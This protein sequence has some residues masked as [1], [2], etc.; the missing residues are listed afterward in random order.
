[1]AFPS[2]SCLSAP[3]LESPLC[4]RRMMQCLYSYCSFCSGLYSPFCPLMSNPKSILA[5]LLLP[6]SA[7]PALPSC[8]YPPSVSTRSHTRRATACTPPDYVHHRLWLPEGGESA[9]FLSAYPVH[10]KGLDASQHA[11]GA[12]GVEFTLEKRKATTVRCGSQFQ[13]F[14]L[15]RSQ[16]RTN[17][18]ALVTASETSEGHEPPP[19]LR[20]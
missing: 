7:P 20:W 2:A 9:L 12:V 17:T 14:L 15:M 5:P 11:V 13:P 10:S 18:L 16:F 1:M 3:S 4:P 19:P 6:V 8:P